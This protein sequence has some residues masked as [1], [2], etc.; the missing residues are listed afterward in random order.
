PPTLRLRPFGPIT[1]LV[2]GRT[3]PEALSEAARKREKEA[4]ADDKAWA[5]LVMLAASRDGTVG[6]ERVLTL[7]SPDADVKPNRDN[8]Y[9]LVGHARIL[10]GDHGD[11]IETADPRVLLHANR[12]AADTRTCVRWDGYTFYRTG[13]KDQEGIRGALTLV[14]GPVADGLF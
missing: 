12:G 2:E 6:W 7:W 1:E 11:H 3:G 5:L 4:S 8:I 13:P 9:K 14:R 10:L